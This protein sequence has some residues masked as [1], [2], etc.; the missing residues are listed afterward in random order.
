MR[1]SYSF[2]SAADTA[3]V[4]G[5]FE[6]ARRLLY[7]NNMNSMKIVIEPSIFNAVT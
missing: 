2:V 3:M 7:Q 6:R 4:S 5:W 1:K